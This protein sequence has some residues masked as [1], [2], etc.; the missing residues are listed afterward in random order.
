MDTAAHEPACAPA[1]GLVTAGSPP[2]EVP[3][4]T[5]LMK[6]G[7][8]QLPMPFCLCGEMFGTWKVP[9]GDGIA[10]PPPSMVRGSPATP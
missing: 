10:R 7:S 9:N 5:A 4:F 1:D 8:L 2:G 3:C 6:S